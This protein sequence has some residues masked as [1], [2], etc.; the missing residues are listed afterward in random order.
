[1][2]SF[3][4]IETLSTGSSH[5]KD[6]ISLPDGARCAVHPESEARFACARC[7][8]FGCAQCLFGSTPPEG[9]QWIEVC[10]ACASGGL[11]EPIPWERRK[12]LGWYRA[13]VDTTKLLCFSPETFFR[14]PSLEKGAAGA[15][16]YGV[17][18]YA[19]GQVITMLWFGLLALVGGATVVAFTGESVIAGLLAG[20]G[21]TFV[22]LSPILLAQAPVQALLGIVIAAGGAHATLALMKRA[23][24]KFED[25]L[26]VIAYAYAPAVWSGIVPGC[27][28][29]VAYVWMIWVEFKAIRE[30]HRCGNDAAAFA[31]L[32]FRVLLLGGLL[33]VYGALAA[34]A[35]AM[36]RSGP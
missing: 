13:F 15:L 18:A 29:W 27:A 7:G 33:V 10:R 8:T 3:G 14:T 32:G 12:A 16:L 30:T 26:R 35:L 4:A 34:F 36:Q 6:R 20:Y 1:M 2:T 25:T 24:V 21:C 28:A 11:D 9:A 5:P 19:V 23:A 31:V 22:G 17:A